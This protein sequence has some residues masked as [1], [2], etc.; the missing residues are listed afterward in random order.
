MAPQTAAP[1]CAE[2][3]PTQAALQ[4]KRSPQR[5][6]APGIYTPSRAFWRGG[7]GRAST[8]PSVGGLPLRGLSCAWPHSGR[9]RSDATQAPLH[10]PCR[11]PHADPHAN[12]S[13]LDSASAHL[14]PAL[15]RTRT[16][17]PASRRSTKRDDVAQV[18]SPV[19]SAGYDPPP[20]L[21]RTT[22]KTSQCV[23]VC[24][25]DAADGPA[26]PPLQSHAEPPL[27]TGSPIRFSSALP[28]PPEPTRTRHLAPL[29]ADR[30]SSGP[31]T[32]PPPRPD[33]V[34]V[35][36]IALSARCT[37][38]CTTTAPSGPRPDDAM[39]LLP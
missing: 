34:D 35:P 26:T 21:S 1:T 22:A 2:R 9:T 32:A 24:D 36:R 29:R 3:L 16:C 10:G 23:C 18:S 7:S 39:Q 20:R 4:G 13:I 6:C 33:A 28:K 14:A 19:W 38:N 8:L 11:P 31:S 30:R 5:H 17:T 15:R 27:H 37:T 25:D 12:K